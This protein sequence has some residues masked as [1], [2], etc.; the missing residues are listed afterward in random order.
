MLSGFVLCIA[1]HSGHPLGDGDVLSIS[2][3]A[4]L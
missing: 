3:R 2:I 4:K 1:F